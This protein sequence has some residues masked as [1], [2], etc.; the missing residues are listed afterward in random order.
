MVSLHQERG[1]VD[2]LGQGEELL[3]Q[4]PRRLHLPPSYIKQ[5]QPPQ[6]G[7]ELWRVLHLLA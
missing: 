6:R 3:P 7:K 4:L 5:P 1:I 2:A